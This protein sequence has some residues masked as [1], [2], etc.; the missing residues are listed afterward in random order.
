MTN[1]RL[2]QSGYC[3][4]KLCAMLLDTNRV[5]PTPK[6]LAQAAREGN[7]HEAIVKAELRDLGC[8][9][10]GEQLDL[11]LTLSNGLDVLGHCDGRIMLSDKALDSDD[12]EVRFIDIRRNNVDLSAIGLLEI[13]SMSANEFRRWTSGEFEVF[14]WYAGQY[15]SYWEVLKPPFGV[16]VVKDRS[17]GKKLLYVHGHPP[18]DF[19]TIDAK[20]VSVCEHV[21]V[22]TMIEAEY[23]H[24]SI[25]CRRC[26]FRTIY[27]K[28][29]AV[30][31]NDLEMI[32]VLRDYVESRDIEKDSKA[33]KEQCREQII[34]YADAVQLDRFKIGQYVVNLS[35]VPRETISLKSLLDRVPREQ[36]EDLINKSDAA[37]VVV[38]DTGDL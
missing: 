20:L 1:L 17:S 12:Y 34:Q 33:T 37:R 5:K 18:E 7:Y 16:Y 22:E 14:P 9:V 36:I 38:T 27:C 13:K 32:D 30:V 23:D 6:Y 10:I 11:H 8:N 26:E 35:S 4:R 2:S 28:P 24:D 25:E 31:L 3:G 15:T 29:D 19:E 21:A